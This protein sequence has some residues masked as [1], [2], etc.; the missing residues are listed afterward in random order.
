MPSYQ[1]GSLCG[2]VETGDQLYKSRLGGSGSSNY[3]YGFSCPNVQIY[4]RKGKMISPF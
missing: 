2:I 4:M 3:A 1:Y